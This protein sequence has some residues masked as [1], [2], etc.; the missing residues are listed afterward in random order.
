M[1]ENSVMSE[2]AEP[3]VEN[4][5]IRELEALVTPREVKD[6]LPAGMD[7]IATVMAGREAIKASLVPD[8]GNKLA[9]IT[10]P[11]S[12]HDTDAALEY[13][14]QI[15]A[16]RQEYADEL[17]I[18]MRVYFEK[19]R[20][21]IGWEGLI[22]DPDLNETYDINKGYYVARK[23][24][25]NIT[26]MGVPTG[27]EI[28]DP[29]TPQFIAG[30]ISWGAIGARTTESPL[31][32]HMASGLSFPLGFKNGT[33]GDLQVAVDAVKAAAY[34]HRFPATDDDGKAAIAVTN[35]NP[36]TH[37]VLRGGRNGPNYFSTDIADATTRLEDANLSPV[38]MID[39]SHANSR[40]DYRKQIEVVRE[41]ARQ[42]S[43]GSTAIMGVMI[44]SNLVEGAQP[45]S[46]GSTHEYGKSITD[47]CVGLDETK[48]MLDLL[49]EAVRARR[50]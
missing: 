34:P 12:I 42:I 15:R 2:I 4:I 16:Y 17:D 40:K 6:A 41:V 49:A 29:L 9:V 45:F 8:R 25:R 32:R 21:T 48:E 35:G 28:L 27:T 38:V 30:L 19:P 33:G 47:A 24:L 3:Q 18:L 36:D 31:H 39:T 22:N 13:A 37:I 5:H 23:L 20:T 10:G 1:E 43:G 50:S 7:S 14:A 11:C 26:A 46:A 44:E